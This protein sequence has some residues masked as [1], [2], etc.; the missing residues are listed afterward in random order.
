MQEI[1]LDPDMLRRMYHNDN[2]T[3]DEI[4]AVFGCTKTTISAKFRQYGI[5]VKPRKLDIP[6]K[7]LKE[8][9]VENKEPPK[10]VA[11]DYGCSEGFVYSKLKEYGLPVQGRRVQI[12]LSRSELED[13]Y[14]RQEMTAQQIA[15]KTKIKPHLI[16]SNLKHFNIPVRPDNS[17]KRVNKIPKQDL[18]DMYVKQGR[19]VNEIGAKFGVTK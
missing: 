12:P 16:Q 3:M 11:K 4:A 14:V 2:K 9:C 6:K 15:D 8:R 19:H 18:E 17:T 5:K 1:P 10:S 13:M 7:V